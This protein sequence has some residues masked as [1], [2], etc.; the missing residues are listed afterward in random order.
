MFFWEK[1][2]LRRQRETSVNSGGTEEKKKLS[3]SENTEAPSFTVYKEL[4][5][6]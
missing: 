3:Q 1:W 4:D 5:I 2:F 6:N